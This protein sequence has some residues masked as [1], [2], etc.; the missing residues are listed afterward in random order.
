[1]PWAVS[2][3]LRSERVAMIQAIA[4]TLGPLRP[5][6]KEMAEQV[7]SASTRSV[8]RDVLAVPLRQVAAAGLAKGL[9]DSEP[10]VP[11]WKPG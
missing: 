3:A 9:P 2:T 6:S 5:M 7:Y 4:L 11:G 1:M 8:R 10:G